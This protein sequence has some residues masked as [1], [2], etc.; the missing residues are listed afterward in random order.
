MSS[1]VDVRSVE[2]IKDF[3]VALALYAE[4][5]LGALGSVNMEAR[6]T[7][8]WVQHDRRN[9]WVDQLK[10]RREKVASA[11][12]EVARR[13]LAKTAHSTPAISEQKEILRHAEASLREA[14]AKIILLRKWEPILQQ[15]VLEYQA[16]TRRIADLAG[17][18]VPRALHL[19]TRLVD[20]LEGYLREAPPGMAATIAGP[21]FDVL[22]GPSLAEDTEIEAEPEPEVE[23]GVAIEPGPEPEPIEPP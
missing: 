6:R 9:Y 19:L 8:H 20:A 21:G 5:T 13:R 23:P 11:R 1:Q 15:A 14:E 22:A 4:E 18:G 12:S 16:G 2:G 17:G 3:R 7:V 10:R